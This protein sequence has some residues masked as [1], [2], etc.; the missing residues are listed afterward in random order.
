MSGIYVRMA[1]FGEIPPLNSAIGSYTLNYGGYFIPAADAFLLGTIRFVES[2]ALDI[3]F[4][5]SPEGVVRYDDTP[6]GDAYEA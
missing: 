6:E 1:R 4:E 5:E 2:P 3:Y